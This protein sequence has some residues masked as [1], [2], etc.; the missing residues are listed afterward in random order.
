MFVWKRWLVV[1]TGQVRS[2]VAGPVILATA[3]SSDNGRSSA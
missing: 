1:D 2:A 3:H